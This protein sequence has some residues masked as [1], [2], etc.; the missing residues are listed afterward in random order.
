M[1]R[2]LRVV[3][4]VTARSLPRAGQLL[5]EAERALALFG[6][7]CA[8]HTRDQ[9]LL[10]AI[11]D[12]LVVTDASGRVEYANAV[13]E[14]ML[15]ARA[16]VLCG[17]R[18]EDCAR[19]VVGAQQRNCVT[20]LF[21]TVRTSAHGCVGSDSAELR[22]SDGVVYGI[23]YMVTPMHDEHGMFIGASF[24]LR[25][26]TARRQHAARLAWSA[27]HDSLT[28]TINRS[29]F[30]RRLQQILQH[31]PGSDTLTHSLL[32]ID[33]DKFKFINDSYGH[34]AG[35]YTLRTLAAVLRTRVRGADLLARLGGDEF[36]ALL[37]AC[38]PDKACL[39]AEGLRAT[40]A[41]HEFVW[42][43]V[44]LPVSLSIGVVAVGPDA[45]SAADLLRAADSACYNAK[46]YGRNRVELFAQADH[47][48][49]RHAQAL[50]VVQEIQSALHGQRLDLFYQPLCSTRTAQASTRYEIGV[51]IRNQQGQLLPH[52]EVVE[53]ATR[54]RLSAAVDR[55]VIKATVDALRLNHPAFDGIDVVLVPLSVQALADD[56][57]LEF[58]IRIVRE[59][60]D[61]AGRLGFTLPEAAL[62]THPELI[63]YFVTT[64]K[65][66]GCQFMI[67][68]LGFG[69]GAIDAVK[70]MQFDYLGIRAS[71]I[72]NMLS[73]SVDYEVVLGLSRIARALG[74]HAVA[75]RADTLPLREALAKMGIEFAK[76][77][78]HD[79]PRRL[80]SFNDDTWV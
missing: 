44:E 23:D 40:V 41:R 68:D 33:L 65:Q 55:W 11:G 58:A 61:Q 71:F 22:R 9:R 77:H 57:L 25:D 21:E 80:T 54:F 76:G 66:D 50:R 56:D 8:Q 52:A 67:G 13:A 20:E 62:A 38:N 7:I 6:Q 43:G 1:L 69:G 47:D 18:L 15:G 73:S 17:Q 39:L 5:V 19:V 46:Q 4:G 51:G 3:D 64:L 35:D 36:C 70:S 30:E 74:M 16:Q 59:H 14:V 42:E 28:G 34:A 12:A 45:H 75:E 26:V 37:H 63:R 49:V 78:T 29:E 2:F 48:T 60:R 79:G 10:R 31:E 32:F 72:D 53:L 24:V 27:A